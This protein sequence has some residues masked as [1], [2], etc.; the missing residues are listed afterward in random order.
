MTTYPCSKFQVASTALDMCDF[1]QL[2]YRHVSARRELP[3]PGHNHGRLWRHHTSFF[4]V[5]VSQPAQ[6]DLSSTGRERDERLAEGTQAFAVLCV[7]TAAY[8]KSSSSVNTS[9]ARNSRKDLRLHSSPEEWSPLPS[10][11]LWR[12]WWR[13]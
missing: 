2:E 4:H 9:T 11:A 3:I 1:R 12:A 5:S 10:T 13:P 8:L 7:G 6:L